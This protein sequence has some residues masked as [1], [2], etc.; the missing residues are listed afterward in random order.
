MTCTFKN[1]QKLAAIID[2][3]WSW[4]G[5]DNIQATAQ[6]GSFPLLGLE[7]LKI[8]LL[9]GWTFDTSV[10]PLATQP[11]S[12][13]GKSFPITRSQN[14]DYSGHLLYSGTAPIF[15]TCKETANGACSSVV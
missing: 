6:P 1:C 14:K 11:P 13:E 7:R 3:V 8:V 10:A 15:A 9:D 12:Y 2:D 5:M 4:V